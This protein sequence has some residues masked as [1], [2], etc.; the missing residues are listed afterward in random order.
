MRIQ[1]N[2]TNVKIEMNFDKP[3]KTQLLQAVVSQLSS[4]VFQI[5]VGDEHQACQLARIINSDLSPPCFH[6]QRKENEPEDTNAVAFSRNDTSK[7]RK[8]AQDAL[9][10][11]KKH[12]S[13]SALHP[14]YV[15]LQASQDSSDHRPYMVS[16]TSNT[17]PKVLP[18]NPVP[19]TKRPLAPHSRTAPNAAVRSSSADR[20]DAD[21]LLHQANRES[22]ELGIDQTLNSFNTSKSTQNKLLTTA[23]PPTKPVPD[24]YSH[25]LATAP[26]IPAAHP[27]ILL[28]ASQDLA[29]HPLQQ[30]QHDSGPSL[31]SV[32]KV[33][34]RRLTGC[35]F[36]LGLCSY[37][38]QDT[39]D[40]F[41]WTPTSEGT[42]TPNT[43]PSTGAGG[44]GAFMF[45]EANDQVEGNIATVTSSDT[46]VAST[47]TTTCT[48]GA[49]AR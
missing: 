4:S 47:L 2:S 16:K 32:P 44:E 33:V 30:D 8:R 9:G 18:V 20:P 35:T 29:D 27:D 41:D 14:P 43:G 15:L 6:E 10:L 34:Q 22:S 28:Q 19:P 36:D 11:L 42:P 38:T 31:L 46:G 48:V 23:V 21:A 1:G 5:V 40:N 39:D 7:Q 24:S 13:I 3:T 37:W 26:F 45:I 17:G 49:S 25:T 12:T